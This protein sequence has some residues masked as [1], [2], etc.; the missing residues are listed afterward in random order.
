MR[1]FEGSF[2]FSCLVC[3]YMLP[4]DA[5]LSESASDRETSPKKLAGAANASRWSVKWLVS[6]KYD[7]FFFIGSCVFTWLVLAFY[8]WA[9]KQDFAPKG[10]AIIVTYFLFTAFFDHPH[11]FQTFSRTHFDKS[12][13][14]KRPFLH[15]WGLLLFIVAGL[16]ATAFDWQSEL[17][18]FAAVF[19]S[20]HIIRQHWGLLRAYKGRNG[21]CEKID[22]WLDSF[23]FYAGMFACFF[24]DYTDIT[25][26]V[27]VYKD[28]VAHFP[29]L[30]A[31]IAEIVW[32]IFI[33]AL[34]LFVLRQGQRFYQKKPLNLPKI[35]FLVAA[36]STHYFVF[37]LTLTPFLV[38]EA[39]ETIYHNFQYQ[40]FMMHYQKKRFKDVRRVALKWFGVSLAYGLV[41]GTIEVLGLMHNGFFKWLF[42]PFSMIVIYHYYVDG[43]IWRFSKEPELRKEIFG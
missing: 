36:L 3:L 6:S 37:F 13:R 32:V 23:L 41:V 33:V 10:D 34:V 28:L 11:I 35:L 30:P 1:I 17:I 31:E 24:Q 18:V 27:V 42:V 26:P 2:V 4:S 38:A 19:G 7:L 21:D 25:S 43:L 9:Q 39:L 29:Y 15:T 14:Q 22:H 5:L 8:V 12:E 20:W 16:I 40:G